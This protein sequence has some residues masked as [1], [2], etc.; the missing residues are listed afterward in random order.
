MHLREGANILGLA[1]PVVAVVGPTAS[2]KSALAQ[3]LALRL[4]GEV[5]GADSMQVYRGMDIGTGKLRPDERKVPHHGIDLCEP[6][7]AYSAAL[8][9]S[10]ARECFRDIDSRCKRPVLCGGT[11]LYVRAALDGYEFPRGAH[12]DN[13]AREKYMRIAE[14]EGA[15]ALWGMLDA[16]DPESAA[17]IHPNNIRR[18]VRA[19]EML[20]EGKS[21]AQHN[22]QLQTIPQVVPAVFLGLAVEPSVLNARIDRR[23]D[24]MV[25]EG[26]VDEV[27]Q[28]L[29]R[30][31]RTHITAP[32]AIGYKEIVGVLEGGAPLGEAVEKIKTATHR[33]AKR[34]RSWFRRDVRIHWL[35]ADSGDIEKLFPQASSVLAKMDV[36]LEEA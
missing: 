35:D 29:A 9:Q 23:V 8:Y 18:V 11:G 2:G 31:F 13:P 20:E 30:G 4:A 15:D 21:Y 33:Y 22:T 3:E 16:R 24:A 27:A 12:A 14:E 25:E 26:L 19:F 7:T 10:Y 36:V 28:L 17:L 5:V 32:Q 1:S 6:D 34:Q